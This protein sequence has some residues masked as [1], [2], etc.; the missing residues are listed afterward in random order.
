MNMFYFIFICNIIIINVE[1]INRLYTKK[2]G[3][4]II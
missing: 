2:K 3:G 4:L 1:R